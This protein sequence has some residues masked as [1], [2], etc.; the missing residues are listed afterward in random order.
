[1]SDMVSSRRR[2]R[3]FF[4][5]RLAY[6]IHFRLEGN[7]QNKKSKYPSKGRCIKRETLEGVL[8]Q[9]IYFDFMEDAILHVG[10]CEL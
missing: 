10:Q 7:N 3:P 8:F 2:K 9:L 6:H 1:M 4:C 5:S